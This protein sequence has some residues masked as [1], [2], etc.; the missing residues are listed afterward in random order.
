MTE[1]QDWS[2]VQ[3]TVLYVAMVIMVE[4]DQFNILGRTRCLLASIPYFG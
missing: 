1:V 3:S 2:L 4:M